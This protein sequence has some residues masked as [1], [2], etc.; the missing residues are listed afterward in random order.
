MTTNATR[1]FATLIFL[2]LLVV[3]PAGAQDGPTTHAI[4]V[5]NQGSFGNGNGSVT[6]HAPPTQQTSQ[7]LSQ[8]STIIQSVLVHE[9]RLYVMSSTAGQVD[10]LDLTTNE[11]VAQV[12]GLVN[13]RY[14]AFVDDDKAYVTGQYYDYQ[15]PDDSSLVQIVDLA[16]SSVTGSI[17]VPRQPDDIV[18]VGDTAYVAL[19]TFSA[20]PRLGV[21]ATA[22]DELVRFIDLDCTAPR[23]MVVDGD[24][25]IHVICSGAS[26]WQTGDVTDPGAIVTVDT[27]TG[28]VTNQIVAEGATLGTGAAG[29]DAYY[30]ASIDA[31]FVIAG[32]DVLQMDASTHALT[33]TLEIPG[34]DLIGA[35]AYD[36]G[37]RRL[38]LGRRD[39][40]AE[41]TN[42]GQVTAHLLDGSEVGA[43]Q[44]GIAPAHI[45]FFQT[46]TTAQEDVVARRH[47]VGLRASYPNPFTT[48]T[49]LPFTLEHSGHVEVEVFNLLGEVVAVLADRE[50]SAG[51]H[52]VRWDA[53]G[54]PAGIYLARLTTGEHVSTQRL[55]HV[56]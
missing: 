8:I 6:M 45:A 51:E 43:F 35:V 44:A 32:S 19:G 3:V 25:D 30:A 47:A 20:T 10:V 48:T 28:T 42:V 46:G 34:D 4:Y 39:P 40:Q 54:W 14:M 55:L 56:R 22:G 49:V 29:Q 50:L 16:S 7:V 2:V 52:T 27:G 13:P 38:Y 1:R 31:V 23:Y 5:A 9:G 37:T 24:D 36:A 33:D 12:A 41:Y 15:N 53:A 11:R 17:E 26:D 18:V 21:I